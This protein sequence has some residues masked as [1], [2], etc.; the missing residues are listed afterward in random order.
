MLHI[1][2]NVRTT[3]ATCAETAQST[4]PAVPVKA[5]F[6]AA[7]AQEIS[8]P[9]NQNNERFPCALAP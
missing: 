1:H 9:D 3:S 8:Q 4:G 5:C 7:A 2:P 6:I